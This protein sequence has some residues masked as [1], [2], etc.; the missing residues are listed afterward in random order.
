RKYASLS[1]SCMCVT[2]VNG[3]KIAIRREPQTF[4]DL[5]PP[6]VL[7]IMAFLTEQLQ[8][9]KTQG[10]LRVV[11][12]IR[13]Q[14]NLVVHDL[15]AGAAPLTQ[16][17]TGRDVSL[18]RLL[19]R[20]RFVKLARPRFHMITPLGARRAPRRRWRRGPRGLGPNYVRAVPDKLYFANGSAGCNS[21]MRLRMISQYSG[22][23]SMPMAEKP[24]CTAARRVVPEPAKGSR[25]V[26]LGGVMR[27]HK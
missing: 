12:V 8:V 26:P 6:M 17:V 4:R 1:L 5:R 25:T 10:N 9:I 3:Y 24:S 27:R 13:R 18:P 20:L 14:I 2:P 15:T 22:S 21:A 16:T 19:P 11:D 7:Q 23:R